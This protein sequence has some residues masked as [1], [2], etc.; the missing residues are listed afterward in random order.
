MMTMQPKA[1]PW[2]PMHVWWDV[3]KGNGAEEIKKRKGG[4]KLSR[5]AALI[6]EQQR[7]GRIGEKGIFCSLTGE[8]LEK[9]RLFAEFA[10]FLLG[11]LNCENNDVAEEIFIPGCI[12]GRISFEREHEKKGGWGGARSLL[13]GGRDDFSNE[14]RG[15]LKRR[16]PFRGKCQGVRERIP[17]RFLR[18]VWRRRRTMIA[19]RMRARSWTGHGVTLEIDADNEI[20]HESTILTGNNAMF[21]TIAII[22]PSRFAVRNVSL[23][24]YRRINIAWS[25][26]ARIVFPAAFPLE[27]D[28]K[29]FL[30][31][32]GTEIY[33]TSRVSILFDSALQFIRESTKTR[34]FLWTYF[35]KIGKG[36]RKGSIYKASHGLTDL[37]ENCSTK[38]SEK[39]KFAFF[40]S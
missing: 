31:T 2:I 27:E 10:R 6:R 8:G 33:R 4:G 11:F 28:F 36:S 34:A 21:E 19:W 5:K 3:R 15:S 23:S 12:R 16:I 40:D 7:G 30:V 38:W 35:T 32:E 14:R 37:G 24:R 9:A 13:C 26:R 1:Q 25:M 18:N 22:D 39:C 17:G 20:M 29:I